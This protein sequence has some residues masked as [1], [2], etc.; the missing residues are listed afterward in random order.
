MP[1][2]K[3]QAG[4][5]GGALTAFFILAA[6]SL[7][8]GAAGLVLGTEPRLVIERTADREFRVSASNHFAG[9]QFYSKTID[10]VSEVVQDDAMRDRTDSAKENRKR[11]KRK[12]LDFFGADGARVGWDR[13]SDQS[14]I[15][16]YM[17]GK[18]KT[19]SLAEPPPTWRMIAA[20]FCVVLG[21]LSFIG[22]IQSSI[23]PKKNSQ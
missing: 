5:K 22:A 11:R 18:D 21:A 2:T 19:L 7:G 4:Q 9:F 10:G 23:F 14:L 17:R 8:I 15:E 3:I 1:T 6:I 16:E 20:W 12:H 13:E